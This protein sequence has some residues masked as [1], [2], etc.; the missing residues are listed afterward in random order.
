MS[1][2]Q[3]GQRFWIRTAMPATRKALKEG[4]LKKL[5]VWECNE[6]I[7]VTGRAEAGMKKYYGA[8]YLPVLMSSE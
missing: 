7:V 2:W 3:Y 5:T 6:M 4:H 1:E 8:T